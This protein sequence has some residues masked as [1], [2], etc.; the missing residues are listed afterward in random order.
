MHG[1]HPSWQRP[2]P[3]AP[4]DGMVLAIPSQRSSTNRARSNANRAAG[5]YSRS[6]RW[7]AVIPVGVDIEEAIALVVA[8]SLHDSFECLHH[9][10]ELGDAVVGGKLLA[11]MQRSM[12]KMSIASGI[13]A[14]CVSTVHGMPGKLSPEILTATFGWAASAFIPSRQMLKPSRLRSR[15]KPA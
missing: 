14:P 13:T 12:P 9:G 5:R 3:N 15:G 2:Q 8:E 1:T 11:N 7:R 6:G 10:R 4:K